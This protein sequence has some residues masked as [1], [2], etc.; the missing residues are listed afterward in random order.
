MVRFLIG[1]GIVTVGIAIYM[2]IKEIELKINRDAVALTLAF[3]LA[4]FFTS[5]QYGF[6]FIVHLIF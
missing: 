5:I 3:I 2:R 1:W 4:L 6:K